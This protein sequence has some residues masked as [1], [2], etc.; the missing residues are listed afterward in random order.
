MK[1]YQNT[2]PLEKR[3][4]YS[5]VICTEWIDYFKPEQSQ[6][7]YNNKTI[8]SR[9]HQEAVSNIIH[10]IQLVLKTLNRFRKLT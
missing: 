5:T 1:K 9:K 3:E 10:T 2:A 4:I 6:Y 7:C 8:N